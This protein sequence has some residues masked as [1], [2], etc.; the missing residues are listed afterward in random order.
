MDLWAY[1]PPP[2]PALVVVTDDIPGAAAVLAAEGLWEEMI[3][4][5]HGAALYLIGGG[6]PV[7]LAAQIRDLNSPL[8]LLN[9]LPLVTMPSRPSLGGGEGKGQVQQ[10][11]HGGS[12]IM[13]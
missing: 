10:V 11:H 1:P 13:K 9:P 3:H 7:P 8:L 4:P 2:P 12:G 6:G 5:M